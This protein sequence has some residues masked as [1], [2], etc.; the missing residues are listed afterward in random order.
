MTKETIDGKLLQEIIGNGGFRKLEMPQK[1]RT[2]DKIMTAA[3][4]LF[5]SHG[6]EETTISQIINASNTSRSAFYHHFHGKE[7]LLFAIAYTYDTSYDLWYAKCNLSLHTI[8]QLIQFNKFVI[9]NLEDS[10][11][12]DLYPSIYGLQVMTS[13]SRHILNQDRHYYKILRTLI[14][15]GQEKGEIDA[16]HSYAELTDMIA[17]M[18]IGLTYSWCL[19]QRRFSLIDY[20]QRLLNPFL[21]TLRV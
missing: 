10:S 11:Y 12:A 2:K 13:V 19:Q 21:E 15:K 20:G 18:Q 16:T 1:K 8:D 3:W 4:E 17:N 5:L 14:K 7:D 6:Y 9:T